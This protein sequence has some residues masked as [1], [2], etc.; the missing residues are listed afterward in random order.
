MLETIAEEELELEIR[1]GVHVGPVVAGVIGTDRF[2]YDV[3]AI[4]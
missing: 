2:S 3:G 1:I 4:R